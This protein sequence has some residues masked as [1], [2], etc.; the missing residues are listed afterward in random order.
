MASYIELRLFSSLNRFTPKFAEKYP[1]NA[2]KTVLDL[3]EELS[4]PIEEV[5]LV[6][7]N[8]SLGNLKSIL[9]GGEKISIFPPLVGG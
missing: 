3:L 2:G 7:I 5:N 6:F 1:I 9:E 4:I 8:G